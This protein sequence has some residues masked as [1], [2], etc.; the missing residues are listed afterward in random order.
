MPETPA[1]GMKGDTD[2]RNRRINAVLARRSSVE[3][4]PVWDGNQFRVGKET[5]R[6]LSYGNNS[7]SGWSDSLSEIR[8]NATSSLHPIDLSSRSNTLAALRR[9]AVGNGVILDI[10][11]LSGYMLRDLQREFPDSAVIGADYLTAGLLFLANALPHVPL[12]QFDLRDC[13]LASGSVDA[14]ILLNVLEHIDDDYRAIEHAVRV[15]KPGGMIVVEVPAGEKLFDFYDRYWLH[16]RRYSMGKISQMMTNAGLDIVKRTH[17]GFFVYPV[18]WLVKNMNL[19][20][21]KRGVSARESLV[22]KQNERTRDNLIM[23][24]FMAMEDALQKVVSLPFGIRAF[25]VGRKP[26]NMQQ[27]E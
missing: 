27:T 7:E 22:V 3:P 20:R 2:D 10:G 21:E 15:L 11:C 17:I 13:P 16:H 12:V 24:W 14:I 4:A 9:H 25:V 6:V 23:K 5:C 18:F 8:D 19:W 1:A 26:I